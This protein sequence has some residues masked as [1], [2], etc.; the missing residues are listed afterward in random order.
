MA[1]LNKKTAGIPSIQSLSENMS[2]DKSTLD[3]L[4]NSAYLKKSA[5]T[6][7]EY[8]PMVGMMSMT[9]P[10]GITVYYEYDSFGRL[11]TVRDHDKNKVNSYH[12]NYQN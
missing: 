5:V 1:C 11:D 10:Q 7:Y 8:K 2:P 12:Y 4:R 3:K 6:T 9:N